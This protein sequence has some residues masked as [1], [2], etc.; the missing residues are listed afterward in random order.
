MKANRVFMKKKRKKYFAV[1]DA[2]SRRYIFH[3][4]SISDVEKH[5]KKSSISDYTIKEFTNIHEF[6]D[7]FNC[8]N[9]TIGELKKRIQNLPDDMYVIYQ[10]IDDFYFNDYKWDIIPIYDS[11]FYPCYHEFISVFTGYVDKDKK[12]FCLTAHY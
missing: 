1:I 2:D 6:R 7:K 8:C 4:Y 10:R 9:Y 11:L 3:E 5:L 12:F